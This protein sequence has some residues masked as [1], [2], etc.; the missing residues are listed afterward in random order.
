MC[1]CRW[2]CKRERDRASE[3]MKRVRASERELVRDRESERETER[4]RERE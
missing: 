1:E 4:E 2:V 3:H